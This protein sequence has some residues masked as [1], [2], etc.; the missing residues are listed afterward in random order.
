MFTSLCA[1][2][3]IVSWSSAG[4]ECDCLCS[5][6]AP[7]QHACRFLRGI[8]ALHSPLF[9]LSHTCYGPCVLLLPLPGQHVAVYSFCCA[10]MAEQLDDGHG[11][12]RFRITA[13]GLV[14]R[15]QGLV[16]RV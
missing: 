7:A 13:Q 9:P 1:A 10:G 14:S 6:G 8:S 16:S 2:C 3:R 15:V 4:A 12:S 11:Y 5:L